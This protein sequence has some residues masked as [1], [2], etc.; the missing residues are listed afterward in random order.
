MFTPEVK[1]AGKSTKT[2][3]IAVRVP[4]QLIAA[5]DAH[6]KRGEV[7]L[8]AL[9]SYFANEAPRAPTPMTLDEAFTQLNN[10]YASTAANE[11]SLDRTRDL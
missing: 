9:E 11:A 10:S 1:L 8:R 2:Q 4:H 6:G 3:V 5:I 7:L